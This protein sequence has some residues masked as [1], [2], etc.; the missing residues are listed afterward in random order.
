LKRKGY[1]VDLLV[2]KSVAQ[3]Q[4]NYGDHIN[5]QNIIE[6]RYIHEEEKRLT[7]LK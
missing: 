1:T 2:K 7:K 3:V 5:N 4:D 6:K